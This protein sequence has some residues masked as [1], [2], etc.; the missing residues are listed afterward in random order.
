MLPSVIIIGASMGGPKSVARIL[1]DL[2]GDFPIPIVVVQH[3]ADGF[4][5]DLAQRFANAS[6]LSVREARDQDRL[7]AGV[8]LV[9]KAGEHLT[10]ERWGHRPV[11]RVGFDRRQMTHMPSID[12]T[13]E[14]AAEIFSRRAVGV[15]LTG[16]GADGA[17]GMQAIRAAGGVTIAEAESSAV[18]FGMPHAAIEAGAAQEVLDLSRIAARLVELAGQPLL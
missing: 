8:A 12:L 11:V 7:E 18:V 14:S 10:F 16:M 6:Q 5:E 2:P 9:A 15:L 3:I 4:T 17:K 13:M 1:K